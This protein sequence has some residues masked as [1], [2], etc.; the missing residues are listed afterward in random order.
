MIHY[1]GKLIIFKKCVL[2]ISKWWDIHT[3]KYIDSPILSMSTEKKVPLCLMVLI[4]RKVCIELKSE[5]Y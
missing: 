4:R 1:A 2:S 5:R 3:Y